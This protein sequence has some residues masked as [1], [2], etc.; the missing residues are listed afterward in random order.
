MF[1]KY[2]QDPI[3]W[4]QDSLAD[5]VFPMQYSIYIEDWISTAEYYKSFIQSVNRPL[6]CLGMGLGWVPKPF[7]DS[8]KGQDPEA[9]V[10]MIKYGRKI[11]VNGYSI[12]ILNNHEEDDTPLIEALTIDSEINNFD[13]P[14]KEKIASGLRKNNEN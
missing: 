2:Q 12:F 7:P 1:L 3:T 14:F 6:T 13:A 4:V 9:T 5:A 8:R 10:K 11:G